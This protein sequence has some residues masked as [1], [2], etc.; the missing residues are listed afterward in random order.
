MNSKSVKNMYEPKDAFTSE[1]TKF[2]DFSSFSHS[3][4]VCR[5]GQGRAM[6]LWKKICFSLQEEI[7]ITNLKKIKEIKKK[8]K[9]DFNYDFK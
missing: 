4:S 8:K 5:W 1:I 9:K 2:S 6:A 3:L 7:K